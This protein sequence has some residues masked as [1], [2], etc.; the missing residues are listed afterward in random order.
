M[1]I[2]ESMLVEI[3]M[4][5]DS[6][7]VAYA[8]HGSKSICA[9]AQ[10]SM[11]AHIFEALTLLLHGVVVATKTINLNLAALK[12]YC[13]TGTLALHQFTIDVDA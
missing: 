8:H 5:S 6:H 12:F 13:L 9:Q 4:D 1:E 10:M 11:L 2:E 3:L 7:V